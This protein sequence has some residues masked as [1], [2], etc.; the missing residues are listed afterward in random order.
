MIKLENN[1]LN[2]IYVTASE[3]YSATTVNTVNLSLKN[4]LT[5]G[6]YSYDNLTNLSTSTRYDKFG[7]LLSGSTNIPTGYYVYTI[8]DLGGTELE[9]GRAYV[10]FYPNTEYYYTGTTTTITNNTYGTW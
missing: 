10:Q 8:E 6:T 2:Y 4:T 1:K 9:V 3:S 5:S 7:V